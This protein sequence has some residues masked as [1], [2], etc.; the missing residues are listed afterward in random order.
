M[1]AKS[2][3]RTVQ[4]AISRQRGAVLILFFMAL[5]LSGATVVL[6]ALNNRNPQLSRALELQKEMQQVKDNL[7]AYSAMFPQ[8]Y[9]GQPAGYGP[10]RLPCPDTDNDGLENCT[11]TGLGRLPRSVQYNPTGS[12][13]LSS[14]GVSTDQ[15][16]W[17]AVH[18]NFW[19]SATTILNSET[20]T[21]FTLDGGAAD[22]VAILIIPGDIVS[23]QVRPPYTTAINYLE[24][25]NADVPTFFSQ[26]NVTP[27]NFNDRVL[28]IRF[29]EVMTL[30]TARAAQQIKIQLDAYYPGNGSSYPVSGDLTLALAGVVGWFTDDDWAGALEN[31][32]R[33]SAT[34]FSVKFSNCG[35]TYTSTFGTPGL[36]R[37]QSSC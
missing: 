16:F 30:A 22:V 14:L 7:L 27:A 5:F 13:E 21:T 8:N 24:G 19:R 12:L 35:I 32:T 17:Y 2:P 6:A 4:S 25:G 29:G 31:Y 34:S 20:T 10:G 1:S 23:N 3:Q 37:D 11:G 36:T 15:Q 26:D 28:A 18:P 33:I 9:A